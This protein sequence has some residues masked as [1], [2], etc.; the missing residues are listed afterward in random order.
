MIYPDYIHNK[1]HCVRKVLWLQLI[2]ITESNNLG[3]LLEQIDFKGT[4]HPK[5]NIYARGL[6]F[7]LSF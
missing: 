6:Y 7:Y 5:V 3:L 4:F 2:L 1:T